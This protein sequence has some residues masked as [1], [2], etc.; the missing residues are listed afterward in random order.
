MPPTCRR[1]LSQHHVAPRL[2]SGTYYSHGA[3]GSSGRRSSLRVAPGHFACHG[4]PR[5]RGGKAVKLK[6]APRAAWAAA[7]ARGVAHCPC[8]WRPD[9]ELVVN[10]KFDM[11]QYRD[12][13]RKMGATYYIGATK[14]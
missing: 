10:A 6:V 7:C 13:L 12:E 11:D 14:G 9:A 1:C 8:V 4:V 5:P 2:A 3:E